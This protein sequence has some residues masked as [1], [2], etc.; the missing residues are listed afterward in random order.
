M[1]TIGVGSQNPAKI[2]AVER[3]S[4]NF[5]IA[6]QSVAVPSGV[7]DQPK[8]DN[9]TKQGAVQR[10]RAVLEKSSADFGVGLEGGIMEI[11][12]QVFVCNWGALVDRNGRVFTA[13]GARIPL[14][15]PIVK[16]LRA[17]LELGDVIDQYT[18][19]L[20]VR[21]GEGTIG[22]LSNG[23]IKRDDMFYHIMQLL[24][25]QYLFYSK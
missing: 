5:D 7:S 1:V 14:P 22:I 16:G 11:D 18:N 19:Q 15:E 24:Y 21:K 20:D 12:Q 17:G 23:L 4:E 9:E 2:S 10:A 13:S 6:V 25:G 8:S 3:L